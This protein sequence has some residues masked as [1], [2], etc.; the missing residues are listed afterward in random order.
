[1]VLRLHFPAMASKLGAA[2]EPA[3]AMPDCSAVGYDVS[4]GGGLDAG[5]ILGLG[6]L[7]EGNGE[8]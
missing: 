6:F 2:I 1:M 5:Y 7:E 4:Q 8:E 3:V